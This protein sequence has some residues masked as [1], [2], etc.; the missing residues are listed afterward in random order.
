[1]QRMHRAIWLHS[2]CRRYQRLRQNLPAIDAL[3]TDLG[4]HPSKQ[5]NLEGLEVENAEYLF[6]CRTACFGLGRHG[7]SPI[8]VIRRRAGFRP[9]TPRGQPL[10]E[11]LILI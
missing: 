11:F 1:M 3:P 4:A 2:P 5:V 10:T 9:H 6:E 7:G 8:E